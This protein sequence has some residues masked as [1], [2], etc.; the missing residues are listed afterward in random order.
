MQEQQSEKTWACAGPCSKLVS[1]SWPVFLSCPCD[2]CPSKGPVPLQKAQKAAERASRG[3]V[4]SGEGA[5]RPGGGSEKGTGGRA[6]LLKAG[7]IFHCLC[8]SRPQSEGAMVQGL[9]C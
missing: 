6:M 3:L 7:Q 9:G 8:A 2:S 5:K 1:W 4:W